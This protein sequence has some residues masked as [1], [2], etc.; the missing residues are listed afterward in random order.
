MP[1]VDDLALFYSLL[2]WK[3]RYDFLP[4]LGPIQKCVMQIL[5]SPLPPLVCLHRC[6]SS[7]IALVATHQPLPTSS[8]LFR[9]VITSSAIALSCPLSHSSA[10]TTVIFLLHPCYSRDSYAIASCLPSPLISRYHHWSLY[11][12]CCAQL[13]WHPV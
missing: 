11:R 1:N 4:L 2:V 8:P 13:L 9:H 7:D 5:A 12:H 3:K 6:L 10:A